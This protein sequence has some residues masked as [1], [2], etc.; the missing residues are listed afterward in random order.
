MLRN[1]EGSVTDISI[2]N[3]GL[4]RTL[5]NVFRIG[6]NRQALTTR[7][8]TMRNTN[9]IHMSKGEW[10]A[11]WL[12]FCMVSPNG[13]G[14]ATHSDYVFKNIRFEEL[15][16]LFGLQNPETQFQNSRFKDITM[17][18]GPVPSVSKN[19]TSGVTPENVM[20]NGKR[21]VAEADMPLRSGS[22]RVENATF[23]PIK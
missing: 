11:P 12:L 8:I 6:F 18:D 1:T 10:Y 2:D 16:A 15:L 23:G 13:K 14:Q 9:V 3:C 19:T 5:A 22:K 20:L 21:V 7:N 4:W 17:Q